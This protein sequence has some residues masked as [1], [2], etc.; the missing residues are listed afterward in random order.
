[1]NSSYEKLA[2]GFI[3]QV[4]PLQT[5]FAESPFVFPCDNLKYGYSIGFSLLPFDEIQ[6]SGIPLIEIQVPFAFDG[7]CREMNGHNRRISIYTEEVK[8]FGIYYLFTYEAKS[9][10]WFIDR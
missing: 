5:S 9:V 6:F 7:Y 2:N 1:M 10:E 4:E 8:K 3:R